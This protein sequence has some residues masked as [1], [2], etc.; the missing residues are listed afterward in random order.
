MRVGLLRGHREIGG[1]RVDLLLYA[2]VRE[3]DSSIRRA[4]QSVRTERDSAGPSSAL[5]PAVDSEGN[6]VFVDPK[7]G[8]VEVTAPGGGPGPEQRPIGC[9]EVVGEVLAN[10]RLLCGDDHSRPEFALD[11]RRHDFDDSPIV[12]DWWDPLAIVEGVTRAGH[13]EDRAQR[14]SINPG[15]LSKPPGRGY[16]RILR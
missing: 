16:E 14:L 2:I 11:R 8:R 13:G 7:A 5:T 1:K 10:H 4:P 6:G 3:T 15:R 9:A 12:D